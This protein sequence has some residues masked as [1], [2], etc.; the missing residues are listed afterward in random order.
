M[1]KKKYMHVVEKLDVSV[2]VGFLE[3][4]PSNIG[5]SNVSGCVVEEVVG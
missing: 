1:C 5:F 2:I 4:E 3:T